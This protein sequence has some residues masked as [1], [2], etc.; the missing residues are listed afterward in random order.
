M[1]TTKTMPTVTATKPAAIEPEEV[2]ILAT[3]L[4]GDETVRL[5]A[6]RMGISSDVM[7]HPRLQELYDALLLGSNVHES[8]R[9]MAVIERPLPDHCAPHRT[10]FTAAMYYSGMPGF[11][12]RLMAFQR[13]ARRRIDRWAPQVLRHIAKRIEEGKAGKEVLHG[14]ELLAFA[15]WT[16]QH[17]GPWVWNPGEEVTK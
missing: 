9:H 11:E 2:T 7:S 8:V 15:A 3:L 13:A 4:T 16:P 14:A 10:L 17:T 12:G 6:R 1:T 5:W